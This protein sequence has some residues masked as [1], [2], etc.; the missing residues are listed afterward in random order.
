ML[1]DSQ[2]PSTPFPNVHF[3]VTVLQVNSNTLDNS[4]RSKSN[5]NDNDKTLRFLELSKETKGKFDVLQYFIK[6]R[7]KKED[8]SRIYEG[9][10]TVFFVRK[11]S[12]F[13]PYVGVLL[14]I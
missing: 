6:K 9:E 3:C 7:E 12:N 10:M 2:I 11:Q 1:F 14:E 8:H 13:G 4:R 5:N